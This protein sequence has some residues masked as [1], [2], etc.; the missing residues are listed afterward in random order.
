MSGND[1]KSYMVIRS[2][3][4]RFAIEPKNPQTQVVYEDQ[5]ARLVESGMKSYRLSPT[6]M[7]R[8]KNSGN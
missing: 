8:S 4:G 7:I 2:N 3:E 5:R 1:D 6:G